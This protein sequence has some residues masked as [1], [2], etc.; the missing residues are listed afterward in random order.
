[1]SDKP[2]EEA[3]MP[4]TTD[5]ALCIV[6]DREI[7]REG[8]EFIEPYITRMLEKYGET[9][10]LVRFGDFTTWDEDSAKIDL[11]FAVRFGSKLKKFAVVN[12]TEGIIRQYKYKEGLHSQADIKYFEDSEL[13]EAIRWVNS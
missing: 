1:M 5:R 12:P 13:Q 3:L 7:T 2:F 6:V 4:E 8:Y 11:D 10:F 9:R